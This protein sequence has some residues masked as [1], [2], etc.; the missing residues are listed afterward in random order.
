MQQE[1]VKHLGLLK[2]KPES[3]DLPTNE[4]DAVRLI[5]TGFVYEFLRVVL[6]RPVATGL[7]DPDGLL[8]WFREREQRELPPVEEVFKGGKSYVSFIY[9]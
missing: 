7:R 9:L 4:Y 5:K 1:L 8:Q 2:V 3:L 6:L